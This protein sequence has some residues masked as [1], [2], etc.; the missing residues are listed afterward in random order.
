MKRT[1]SLLLCFSLL[2]ACG[3]AG[4]KMAKKTNELRV[5]MS[6]QEVEDIMEQPVDTQFVNQKM[7]CRYEL[8]QP[9]KGMVPYYL[10]YNNDGT[11]LE[12][13]YADEEEWYRQK[14]LWLKSQP[15][16]TQVDYDVTIRKQ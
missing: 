8:Y 9:S 2:L 10:V 3:C 6:R 13:W 11:Y 5:G 1:M 16:K 15:R 14:E 7:V 4:I 12:K